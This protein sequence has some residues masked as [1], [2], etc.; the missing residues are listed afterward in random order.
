M[1]EATLGGHK[2][3]WRTVG[4]AFGFVLIVGVVAADVLLLWPP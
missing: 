1:I 3:N 4:I 2:M